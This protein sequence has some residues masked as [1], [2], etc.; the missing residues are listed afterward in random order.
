MSLLFPF[1]KGEKVEFYSFLPCRSK[2]LGG[3]NELLCSAP[4]SPPGPGTGLS[5]GPLQARPGTG[6]GSKASQGLGRG[7]SPCLGTSPDGLWGLQPQGKVTSPTDWVVGAE[8]G[9]AGAR[10]VLESLSSP[11]FIPGPIK[12]LWINIPG[13]LQPCLLLESSESVSPRR[14]GWS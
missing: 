9:P 14:V 2:R 6:Q 3:S 12:C 8:L 4:S 10:Q 11:A 5:M 1:E 13:S 7:H